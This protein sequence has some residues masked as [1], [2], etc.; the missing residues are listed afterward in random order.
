MDETP[1]PGELPP[2]LKLLKTLVTLLMV[3]M[4]GGFLV[5]VA[6][7][8]IRMPGGGGTLPLPD[9]ISLPEGTQATA[10]TRGPN[11]F[12]VVTGDDRILIY[13]AATGDLRQTVQITR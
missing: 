7:F 3:T 8:V 6:L 4:I 2:N 5:I 13:D 11:W 10:F 1:E 12:A 9:T